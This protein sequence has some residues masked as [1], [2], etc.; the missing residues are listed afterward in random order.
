MRWLRRTFLT[1]LL[2]LLPTVI[3]AYVLYRIFVWVDGFLKPIITRY[4][5]L[6]IPGLGFLAVVV[7]V[8]LAGIFGANLFGRTLYKWFEGGFEKIPLVRSIYVAI[9]QISEVFLKQERTVFKK[10]V[11]V[12][13]P[14]PGVYMIGFVTSSWRFRDPSGAEHEFITVFL[15][16]SPNPTT[17]FLVIIAPH[18]AI[19]SDLSVEDAFKVVISG[20]AVVPE[21]HRFGSAERG[22]APASDGSTVKAP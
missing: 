17:G 6:D 2:V 7:I 19:P 9:K 13:Y 15:P 18:E 4:P 3:T 12:E 10:V 14:R 21:S 20:G 8:L 11:L 1:G 16:T 22:D 5:F